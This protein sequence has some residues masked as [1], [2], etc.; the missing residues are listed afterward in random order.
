MTAPRF[1]DW[2]TQPDT[3]P[4]PRDVCFMAEVLEGRHGIHAAGVADFF[5]AYHGE[6]GDA[7]RAW[8]WSGV[9]ELVRNRERERIE[10]R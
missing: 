2:D 10:R 7:G 4:T 8:A 3:T 1:V 9:A 5:A 6:K